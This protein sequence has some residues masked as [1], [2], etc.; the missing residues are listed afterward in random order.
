MGNVEDVRKVIQDFVAPDLKALGARIVA[1]EKETKAGF[2]HAEQLNL[3]RFSS[4]E[5]LAAARHEA[6]MAAIAANQATIMNALEMDKR[7]LRL[8]NERSKAVEVQPA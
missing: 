2:E 4:I 5:K 7:L 6:V 8:E 3:E 1:L